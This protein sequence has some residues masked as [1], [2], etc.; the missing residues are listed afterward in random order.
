MKYFNIL[1]HGGTEDHG[2]TEEMQKPTKKTGKDRDRQKSGCFSASSWNLVF[3]SWMFLRASVV[4]RVS[5]RKAV[6]LVSV[7]QRRVFA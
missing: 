5:V 4:L 7:S 1:S 3:L 6:S 2:G